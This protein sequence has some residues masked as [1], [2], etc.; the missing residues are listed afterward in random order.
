METIHSPLSHPAR[1]VKLAPS[2]FCILLLYESYLKNRILTTM[3]R[4]C[5]LM[6]SWSPPF[7]SHYSEYWMKST[8]QSYTLPFP[9]ISPS[10]PK[11]TSTTLQPPT[12]RVPSVLT[13]DTNSHECSKE[14]SSEIQRCEHTGIVPHLKRKDGVTCLSW[15]WREARTSGET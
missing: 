11:E 10:F 8:Q 3:F 5:H 1:T 15:H 6:N 7:T 14:T 13:T 9:I 4:H 12:A 2:R